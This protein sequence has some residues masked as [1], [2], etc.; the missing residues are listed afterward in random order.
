[1]D[2]PKRVNIEGKTF[3]I[4]SRSILNLDCSLQQSW[5]FVFS[6]VLIKIMKVTSSV[7]PMQFLNRKFEYTNFERI[8][9]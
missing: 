3:E 9:S 5:D 1:M 2:A 6:L 8:V 7:F 4:P